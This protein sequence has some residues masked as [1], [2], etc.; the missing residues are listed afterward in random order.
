MTICV[1]AAQFHLRV[2]DGL[3]RGDACISRTNCKVL[4]DVHILYETGVGGANGFDAGKKVKV[5]RRNLVFNTMGL[6][7]ALIATAM[8]VQNRDADSV[9]V[10][11]VRF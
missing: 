10:A 1:Q 9:G 6:V 2:V 4:T 5:R 8:S 7:I 3:C 11:Q